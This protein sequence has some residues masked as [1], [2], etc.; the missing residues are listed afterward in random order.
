MRL[1]LAFNRKAERIYKS[2]FGNTRYRTKQNR[3]P[4][5]PTCLGLVHG[6]R[7][8]DSDLSSCICWEPF[9]DPA[10]ANRVMCEMRQL[11]QLGSKKP[12]LCSFC[13]VLSVHRQPGRK[14]PITAASFI[15]GNQRGRSKVQFLLEDSVAID[16]APIVRANADC[17]AAH[18]I[19]GL[20]GCNP[21][22]ISAP[23][24]S[25]GQR[26]DAQ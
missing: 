12:V 22:C 17:R 7:P 10:S 15:Q 13:V 16:V 19:T 23:A 9:I 6:C 21:T 5:S 11:S 3:H 20:M 8:T 26:V 1:V 25:P 18:S 14:P 2:T 4:S 24:A